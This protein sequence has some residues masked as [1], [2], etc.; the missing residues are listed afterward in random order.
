MLYTNYK[1][2]DIACFTLS[3][4]PKLYILCQVEKHL[5][6]KETILKNKDHTLKVQTGKK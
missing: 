1:S 5:G 3:L 4:P 2:K 6:I